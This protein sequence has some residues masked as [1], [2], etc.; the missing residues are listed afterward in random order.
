[1]AMPASSRSRTTWARTWAPP[2]AGTVSLRV[3]S[4]SVASPV[5]VAAHDLGSR[6]DVVTLV[7]DDL[8]PCSTEVRLEFVGRAAGDDLAAVDDGDRVG[9][10]VGLL[11]VLG[12]QQQG[13]A[14]ADQAA[15]D[16]PHPEAAARVEPGRGLVEEQQPRPADQGAAQVEPA[17]HAAGVGLDDPVAGVGQLELVEQLLRPLLGLGL[18]ELVEPAEHDQVLPA[19]QVLVDGRVL[20]GESDDLPKL[21]GL[22][23]HVE[24]RDGGMAGVRLQ[25]RGED[26][27]AGRLAGAVRAEQ[28][29]DGALG[30]FQVHAVEGADL[31][32]ARPI[33]LDQAFGRDGVHGGAEPRV[34]TVGGRP[35]YRPRGGRT[36]RRRGGRPR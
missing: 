16:L 13:R 19:G 34:R 20:A 23:D 28:A 17:P 30:D 25:E 26:P 36:R 11:E 32:L 7:D 2:L 1:M 10:F 5:A 6:G 29:Q 21:L 3:C 35:V 8:H 4:S 9:Q 22:L 27:D 33:D 24:A 18:R 31:V 15:D 14:L 12:R